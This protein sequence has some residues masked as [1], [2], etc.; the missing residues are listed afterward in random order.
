VK[1]ATAWARR[2][3][4]AYDVLL[5][6]FWDR[7]RGL[8]RIS[9]RRGTWPLGS[10]HYWWQ[11][12]ALDCV[13]D[14]VARGRE[15]ERERGRQLV[16]G[17]LRRNGGDLRN[18]YYD[19]LAWMALAL[20]RA[21]A[22]AGVP[23]GDLVPQLWAQIRGGWCDGPGGIRW[24]RADRYTNAP[25]NGPAAILAA[26]RYRVTGDAADLE[27]ACRITGWLDATLVDPATGIVWD[28]IHPD[29]STR[30]NRERYSYNQGTVAAAYQ[31]L[32][33]LTGEPGY[34]ERALQVARAGLPDGALP[35]G[36]LPDGALPD[37]GLPGEG[38]PDGGLPGAGLP[39][40]GLPAGGGALPDEG[41]PD[42]GLPGAGLPAGRGVLPDEGGGDRALFK[43]IYA[44]YAA[45]L[46][47]PAL[48]AALAGNGEAAWSARGPDGLCGQSWT[49]PPGADV[50]LSA[51]LSGVLL[52]SALA[53]A[54]R[55]GE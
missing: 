40:E 53:A 13:V 1:D 20:D 46:G 55:R 9:T 44:R 33:A 15:A 32:V 48:T 10:W 37:G 3:D 31:E 38:L 17:V 39:G 8:F 24:R 50:E 26:R 14:A 52:L 47:D 49:R 6:R 30:P 35:D 28:G 11:A 54:D 7:S 25:T 4:A 18:D 12:H 42:G 16:R 23:S 2:A 19:D 29:R 27:W 34:R 41:L 5:D 51:H 45:G 22:V 43:G 21:E 36:A